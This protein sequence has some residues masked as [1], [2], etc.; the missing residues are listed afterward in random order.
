MGIPDHLTSLLRNLYAGQEATLR[1]RHETT[2][3]SQ[4]VKGIHQSCISSPCLFN[5]YTEYIK[6]NARLDEAQDGIKIARR[7]IKNFRYA[8]DT[9]FMSERKEELKSLLMKVKRRLKKLV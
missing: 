1:I 8:G 2:N 4:I 3:W 9:T 7:N 6:Q 5:L